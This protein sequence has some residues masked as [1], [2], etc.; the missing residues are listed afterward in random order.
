MDIALRTEATLGEGPTWD[1]RTATLLWLDILRGEI[2]RFDPSRGID[3]M[4]EVGQHVGAAKPRTAG[5]L[6]ANLVEG[7]ALLDADGG[8]RWLV[9]WARDGVRGN[10]A[11]VDPS[12][13]LW[14]GTM[15]YDQAAGGG[16][17]AR[18]EPSGDAGTVLAEVSISNGIGWSPDG[19]RM[20][21]IDSPT[22]RIDVFDFD[23]AE[24]SATNRRPLCTV[25][26]T[27]G[28]PDG[29][30]VD[31]SGCVW[32]AVNGGGAVRR[33]TPQGAL[34]REVR[35]PVSQVSAC[36]FGGDGLGD[37]YATT[38]RE[39][40]TA[41]QLAEQPLSGSLFVL[42]GAGNGIAQPLFAG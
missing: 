7:V 15:R 25:A 41:Q 34:D 2:H 33:Y 32:V 28:V 6:V 23:A 29:L 12:G 5:G 17:L 39:G 16:W 36:C 35:L 18:V 27:D 22:H 10:D 31:S 4:T 13:R 1:P 38:A 9:Y 30:C 11:G 26:D 21:Y 19:A 20:Y 3:D 37:L 42:P 24:G 40:M 8:R 14:A